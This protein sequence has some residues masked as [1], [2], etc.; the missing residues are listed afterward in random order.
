MG[1][2]DRYCVIAGAVCVVGVG[3]RLL[4]LWKTA[5]RSTPRFRPEARPAP[6]P[7]RLITLARTLWGPWPRF[8]GRANPVWSIGCAAYHLAIATVVLGYV[9]SL[10]LLVVRIGQG[11]SLPDALSGQI[12]SHA[13]YPANLAALVVGNSEPA[14]GR[15]L[16]GAWHPAFVRVT[17]AEVAFALAGNL[18]LLVSLLRRRMGAVLRDLDPAARDIRHPG[19]FSIGHFL[20]RALVF[21]IVQSELAARLNWWPDGVYVHVVLAMTFLAALPYSYLAH[22]FY[23]PLAVGLAYRRRRDRVTA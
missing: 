9:L 16:F 3:V 15:F 20:V 19:R 22:I 12:G 4:R 7:G 6:Q 2:L 1:W 5:R 13:W 11:R 21:L 17:H 8:C 14:A 18:C 10:C 23:S